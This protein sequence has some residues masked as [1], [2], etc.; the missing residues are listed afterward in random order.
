MLLQFLDWLLISYHVKQSNCK[1]TL[2]FRTSSEFESTQEFEVAEFFSVMDSNW[3]GSL[4]Q[5]M[6]LSERFFLHKGFVLAEKDGKYRYRNLFLYIDIFLHF[7][8]KIC[9][10]YRYVNLKSAISMQNCNY[11]SIYKNFVSISIFGN[12]K[13][14]F[15]KLCIDIRKK[16]FYIDT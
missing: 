5:G 3:V 1:G 4:E 11:A 16:R 13:P 10:K 9:L 2:K 7:G 15:L 14:L 6:P 8:Q 12:K